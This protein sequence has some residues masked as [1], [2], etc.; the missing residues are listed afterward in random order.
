MFKID[1]FNFLLIVL[2]SIVSIVVASQYNQT[3]SQRGPIV[4]MTLPDG[5]RVGGHARIFDGFLQLTNSTS[6]RGEYFVPGING[7]SLGWTCNFSV[8]V[9]GGAAGAVADGFGLAWGNPAQLMNRNL[10]QRTDSVTL[11]PMAYLLAWIV[12]TFA[13]SQVGNEPGFWLMNSTGARFS[14][15]S[16]TPLMTREMFNGTVFAAWNPL[17]GVTFITTGFPRINSEMVDV[18]VVFNNTNDSFG[19]WFVG[20]SGSFYETVLI[21]QVTIMTPCSDCVASNGTCKWGTAGRFE[22]TF[23]LTLPMQTFAGASETDTNSTANLTTSM[24]LSM[25]ANTTIPMMSP[26]FEV[27]R[28]DGVVSLTSAEIGAILGVVIGVIAILLIVVIALFISRRRQ[29]KE[30]AE[31]DREQTRVETAMN[32]T[33]TTPTVPTTKPSPSSTSIYSSARESTVFGGFSDT[34]GVYESTNSPLT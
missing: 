11:S 7:S 32:Q 8:T 15:T 21:D 31:G 6:Q 10:I 3:F 34:D 16:A 27:S 30:L 24:S 9:T 23:P 28:A 29:D 5:T 2:P 12:D 17:H 33:T 1:F 25:T 4:N 13:N 22:C 20:E 18:P 14:G 26:Q 19:W